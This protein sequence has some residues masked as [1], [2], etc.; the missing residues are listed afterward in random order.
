MWHAFYHIFFDIIE[1]EERSTRHPKDRKRS[2]L[3]RKRST[4]KHP[5]RSLRPKQ[6]KVLGSRTGTRNAIFN[7]HRTKIYHI[8]PAQLCF[9]HI[10]RETNLNECTETCPGIALTQKS[11]IFTQIKSKKCIIE[12]LMRPRTQGTDLNNSHNLL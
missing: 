6:S 4:Q 2:T 3:S 7:T 1:N 8:L 10:K 5:G 9:Q 11:C 12:I